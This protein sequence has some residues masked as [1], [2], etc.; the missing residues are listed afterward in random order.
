MSPDWRGVKP[1]L[2]CALSVARLCLS[3]VLLGLDSSADVCKSSPV[4]GSKYKRYVRYVSTDE[5]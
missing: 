1:E 5:Q 3:P 4:G 2:A